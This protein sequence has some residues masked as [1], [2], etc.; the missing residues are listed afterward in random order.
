MTETNV[1]QLSQPGTFVDPLTEVL[2]NG[3]RALLAQA[4]EAEIA[5][6]LSLHADKLTEDGRQW[7]VRHGHLPEREIMTGIS[8]VAVRYP[9]AT[10]LAKARAHPFFLGDLAALRA[11]LE[12]PRD[13]QKGISDRPLPPERTHAE[14]P[15]RPRDRP[16][17]GMADT[18]CLDTAGCRF[19]HHGNSITAPE[20]LRRVDPRRCFP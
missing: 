19:S 13:A 8:P 7:L 15:R 20:G 10:G 3:A 14:R 11:P 17:R 6:L 12:E 2:R 9:R 18:R 5:A 4:I 1:F 16:V